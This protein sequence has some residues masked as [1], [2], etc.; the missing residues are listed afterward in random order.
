MLAQLLRE[1]YP[2]A[3][4]IPRLLLLSHDLQDRATWTDWLARLR[5]SKVALRVPVRGRRR[6]AVELA[7]RNAA[8]RLG[9]RALRDSLAAGRRVE[10]GDVA[11][12]EALGLHRV[13]S[14]IECFDISN[15]QDRETVGSLV[16]F[17]DGQPLK[18]RYRRFRVRDVS[19]P[20][21]V[22]SME[23]V[24]DRYYTKVEQDGR[25]PA[26]LVVVDGG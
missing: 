14:T 1:Y 20:N 25:R 6:E 7:L 11:L 21:D 4:D 24:L 23:E 26:D 13:P 8:Y 16:Y 19:G 5:G 18:S 2:L 15:Y 10:P 12:Q 17:K 3:S 9:E 22:K